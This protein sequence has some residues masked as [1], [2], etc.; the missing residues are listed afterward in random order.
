MN[1]CNENF[2][3]LSQKF[4]IQGQVTF[5]LGFSL[6]VVS[7][8]VSGFKLFRPYSKIYVKKT[9]V[10]NTLVTMILV[11]YVENSKN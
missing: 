3:F 5:K 1:Q 7:T 2:H 11:S 6:T 10:L 9:V 4:V 8:G